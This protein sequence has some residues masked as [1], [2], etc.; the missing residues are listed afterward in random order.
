MAFKKFLESLFCS[1]IDQQNRP[2]SERLNFS[3]VLIQELY[4]AWPERYYD[5]TLSKESPFDSEI[6]KKL[7]IK[8]IGILQ[9][10]FELEKSW[11]DR[12][13]EL[14]EEAEE[15]YT[16]IIDEWIEE[17]EKQS[18]NLNIEEVHQIIREYKNY[19]P[20]DWY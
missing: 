11:F 6:F 10:L 19:I 5:I 4:I 2:E 1:Y 9:L 18:N 20:W 17:L 16:P 3:Q 15:D 12:P 13:K 8:P 7:N 14:S